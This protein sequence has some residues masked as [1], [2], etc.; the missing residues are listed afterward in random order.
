M[1]G[2]YWYRNLRETVEFEQAT[3]TLLDLGHTA[4]VEVG[5]H[6]VLT[7]GLEETFEAAGSNAVALGTLRRDEGG[8]DRFLA[9]LAEAWA[10]GVAVD[11]TTRLPDAH[12]GA[13]DL[14]TYAFRRRRYWL[15]EDTAADVTGAGL[16][17]AGHPLLGAVVE[18]A[19]GGGVVLS[20]RFSVRTHPW[21]ADHAVG[22]TVL[23]PGTAFV[24]LAVRAGDAAG[25]ARLDELTLETPLVV[26]AQGDVQIQVVVGAADAVGSRPVAVHARTAADGSWS[27]HASGTLAET[28]PEPPRASGAPQEYDFTAWPP[29]GAEPVPVDD[30]YESLTRRGYGYGPAFQGLRAAW[31]HGDDVFAEVRLPEAA[32]ARAADFGIHPALLDAALH[33]ASLSG[34]TPDDGTWLPFSWSGTTL[35]ATGA[36]DVRVRL[37]PAGPNALRVDIADATG[38]PVARADTL[39]MRPVT[40]AQLRSSGGWTSDALFRVD[41]SALPPTPDGPAGPVAVIGEDPWAVAAALSGRGVTV[42][43][44]AS[45]DELSAACAEGAHEVPR[46]ALLCCAHAGPHPTTTPLHT[47]TQ[48]FLSTAQAWLAEDGLEA[49]RLVAVTRGAVAAGPFD[50][51]RDLVAAPVW[52]LFRSAQAENPGRFGLVDL[53][54]PGERQTEEAGVPWAEAL[55]DA[56]RGDEPQVAVRDARPLIPRLARADSGAGLAPPTDGTPWRLDA[57]DQGTLADLAFVPCPEVAEPL[58]AGEVRVAVRAAGLNFRDVVVGLGMVP[59]QV[60]IGSEGAGVVVDVGPGVH[61]IAAGDRVMGVMPGAFGPL[62]VADHRM[63]VP[64]PAGWSFEQAAAVPMVFLTAYYAL[65]D[66]AGLSEGESVLVHAAAGGV[67]MAATQLA[68]HWG[69]EVYGTASPGK[70]PALRD[71]GLD[72]THLAH[73]RTLAFEEKF[74]GATDGAGF[75]VVLDSLSGDF[76][77][78]SLRLLP[79]GGRFLEMGKADKRDPDEVA[80]AHPGVIYRAFDLVEAGPERVGAML[81]DIVELFERGVLSPLPVRTWDLRQAG[82][83]FRFMSQARHTG[84]IVLTVPRRMDPEGSALI[85]G[86]TGVLG[87]LMARHLVTA[88]GIRHLTLL[89]RSGAHA[90]GAAELAAELAGHGAHVTFAACDAADR[91]ALARVI[92]AIPADRPLTAVVHTAG[93]LDDGVLKSLTPRHLRTVL[94]PKADA[95]LH[96]HELTRHMDLAAF[97]LFSSAAGVLGGPGQANYAAANAFLDALAAHRR[98]H[99]LPA[100]SL[101]WGLWGVDS[102]MT[103]QLT[104]EDMARL[105]RGGA[106]P[107]TAE[108]G[109]ALFDAGH[110]LP[111]PLVMAARMDA[112]RLRAQADAGTVPLLW[113]GLIRPTARPVAGAGPTGASLVRR[114]A[115]MPDAERHRTLLELVRTHLAVVLGHASPGAI[116]AGRG[117]LDLGVDSLTA[118]ELRNRLSAATGARLPATVVF[119][120]PNPTA[121]ARR[122]QEELAPDTADGTPAGPDAAARPDAD[123]AE[124]RRLLSTIPVTRLR[125]TGVL[126]TLLRLAAPV[127]HP[128]DTEG[129]DDPDATDAVDAMDTIDAMGVDDLLRMVRKDTP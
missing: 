114:L 3:R 8:M 24:E 119:D 123:E 7:V 34:A 17:A 49:C 71:L 93:V 115:G 15:E 40:A 66:L 38:R 85:T 117:F 94:R 58:R 57:V 111:D 87:G 5:V 126:D 33:A 78:A 60:G 128:S 31:R 19:D 54:G 104:R 81:T 37:A 103:E 41:W 25:C 21:L 67:G 97:V 109:M 102:A 16:D 80:A 110:G 118:V 46:T 36:T 43:R 125:E 14:P 48:N 20:G 56:L 12:G 50:G 22:R 55:V 13:V 98:A 74:L 82:E 65:A 101:A 72:D 1:G 105:A 11:W 90:P 32:R 10:Q 99:G 121:L 29:S 75:D 59:G 129:D 52:G 47:T 30:L 92:D 45:I 91:T 27:R 108:Q 64:M 70:W 53:E 39:T 122:L 83:A 26:P 84:K 23:V 77:D 107:L 112:T 44:Y 18:L 127:D 51:V 88:H 73:S 28:D 69:A 4:F 79:R 9:S 76:V 35:L 2:E 106:L 42:H 89:S 100:T 6:P 86:G 96:L 124:V 113:Q 62:T 63:L 68:R 61:G 116:E 95:A 120:H